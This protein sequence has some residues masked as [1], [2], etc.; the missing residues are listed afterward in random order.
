[1]IYVTETVGSVKQRISATELVTYLNQPNMK[2]QLQ[3]GMAVENL[4]VKTD[5]DPSK[6]KLYLD[7]PPAGIS[8]ILN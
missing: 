5:L 4:A 2:Q 6:L 3:A 8:S 7:T 1:M